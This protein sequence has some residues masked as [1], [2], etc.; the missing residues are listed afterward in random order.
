MNP[1]LIALDV[2]GTLLNDAHQLSE[3]NRKVIQR[4]VEQGMK[5]V[6]CTGRGSP[7]AVPVMK[8]LNQRGVMITHNGS[9][10]ITTEGEIL[11]EFTFD[12]QQI[13]GLIDYCRSRG[14]HFDL[15]TSM[16]MYIEHSPADAVHMYEQ[17]MVNP[18]LI[19]DA[20]QLS[21]PITKF[22]MFAD[23]ATMDLV[24]K[25][26]PSQSHE[27]RFIRS[28]DNF[29]DVMRSDV[30]KGLALQK[31]AALWGIDREEIVAMGNYYNDIEM[32]RFAGRGVAVANSPDEVKLA[33]DEVTVSNNEDA[34]YHIL[35]EY[36]SP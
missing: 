25:D 24:E 27:L 6:L 22:T 9:S 1:K 35:K 36:V 7:S 10:T 5:L 8:K 4:L 34:V 32:L 15:N 16:N 28:G 31:L 17:F 30:T 14:I 3:N 23:Q 12:I 21:E 18:D 2:D 33:A 20:K 29:I 26:W 19:A 11:H 13:A